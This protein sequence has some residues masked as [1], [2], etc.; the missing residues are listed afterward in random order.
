MKTTK[1]KIE[2]LLGVEL[3]EV[4]CS[5]ADNNPDEELG[6]F[7]VFEFIPEPIPIDISEPPVIAIYGDYIQLFHDATPYPCAVNTDDDARLMMQALVP[8][9]INIEQ[10]TKEDYLNFIE[11]I[12][13]ELGIE[14]D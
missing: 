6:H 4:Y 10:F 1:E 8:C 2:L 7:K 9:P 5:S 11:T 13:E 3:S 14:E 12:R